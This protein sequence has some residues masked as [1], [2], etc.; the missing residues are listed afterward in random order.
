[1]RKT[2]D[3]QMSVERH[4]HRV[5]SHVSD[6]IGNVS[7]LQSYNRVSLETKALQEYTQQLIKRAVSG[8]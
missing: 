4:Y 7:V 8:P 5:F 1:M 2:K 3:G 6:A